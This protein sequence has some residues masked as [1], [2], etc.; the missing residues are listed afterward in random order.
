MVCKGSGTVG[1]EAPKFTIPS[2]LQLLAPQGRQYILIKV[3]FAMVKY[4]M[5]RLSYPNMALTGE[6]V[7]YRSSKIKSRSK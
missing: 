2:Y 7:G 1:R 4:A 5:G 6:G 3:K